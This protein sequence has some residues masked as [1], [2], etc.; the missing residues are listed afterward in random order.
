MVHSKQDS[1]NL[2]KLSTL[3]DWIKAKEDSHKKM[4]KLSF[5]KKLEILD[6]MNKEIL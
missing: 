6:K 4:S 5:I 1:R 3:K 2:V